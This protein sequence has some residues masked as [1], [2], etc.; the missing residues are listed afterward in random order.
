MSRQEDHH[1]ILGLGMV[2]LDHPDKVEAFLDELRSTLLPKVVQAEAV[3]A[4]KKLSELAEVQLPRG[5]CMGQRL[6][7]VPRDYLG[8][9]LDD[10]RFWAERIAGYLNATKHL[11]GE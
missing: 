6:D 8:W 10:G 1:Q 9:W 7:D 3:Q 11:H 5:Q 4:Q 2:T